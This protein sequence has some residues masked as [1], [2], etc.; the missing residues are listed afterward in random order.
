MRDSYAS[1]N[2]ASPWF[3]AT[4]RNRALLS[5]AVQAFPALWTVEQGHLN[6]LCR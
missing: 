1:E 4:I 3:V 6:L 2:F 5:E